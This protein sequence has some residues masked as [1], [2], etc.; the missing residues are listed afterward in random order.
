MA[1]KLGEK[2]QIL[3]TVTEED[4]FK[5]AEMTG[6][7]NP[8][9]MDEM[10]AKS[11]GFSGRIAH[12]VL[13]IGMISAVLGTKMPGQGTI[14]LEQNFV[15]KMPVFMGDTV[16]AVCEVSEI[17]NEV[18]GIYRIDTKCFNQDEKLLLDGYAV[19]KYIG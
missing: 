14:L 18:K 6:D 9:H 4:V 11:A 8:I 3:K 10:V 19:V 17:I 15:Y 2:A 5:C 7:F 12:G 1:L 16:K 13:S